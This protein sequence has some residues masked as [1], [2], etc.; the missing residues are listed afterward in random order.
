MRR[1][2]SVMTGLAALALATVAMPCMVGCAE[3][4]PTTGP[5]AAEVEYEWRSGDFFA[6]V[7]VGSKTVETFCALVN[8]MSEGR[9]QIG[10]N[11][12]GVLG[13]SE[14]L[15]DSVSRGELEL[16]TASPYSGFHELQNLKGI[17][18][19]GA[20]WE[21]YD[22]LFYGEGL[23]RQMLN[24]SW[25]EIGLKHLCT[26]EYGPMC[27]CNSVGPI[28]TP[29][30]F[31]GLK[32]RIP[33]SDVYV[34]SFQNM[35]PGGMGEIIPWS[36]VYS[37]IERGVVDGSPMYMH[38]YRDSKFFEVA[39]YFTDV[40]QCYIWDAYLINLELWD[41]LPKDLQDI[42]LEAASRAED[43][44]RFNFRKEYAEVQR[45]LEER[46]CVFTNLTGA[47]RQAFIDNL[48]PEELW[49]E[50]YKP[51]LEKYYPGQNKYEQ[52][53]DAVKAVQ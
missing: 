7:S 52:L 14:E 28:V 46:G 34:K 23:I 40:N 5:G 26:L 6:P 4:E 25:E 44:C 43:Y 48:R 16:C 18:F 35:A 36:E 21:A 47:E 49:Q 53:I 42:V 45:Q 33:P 1:K 11:T 41:S 13:G 10:V 32:I 29:D 38:S 19:A 30:D 22:A 27:Y 51:L 17:P 50:L 37:A 2:V 39:K 3:T 15:V 8:H 31:D 12:G 24:D 20:T 9:M